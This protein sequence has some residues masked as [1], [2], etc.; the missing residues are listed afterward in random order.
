MPTY[1]EDLIVN[2]RI[3]S[4]DG[5][6]PSTDDWEIIR[7]G[8]N[9]EIREPE[10][11]KVWA[12][13]SD[14]VSLHL[15]GTPNLWVDG[16]IGVG[17]TNTAAKIEIASGWGD[18]LFLRQERNLEGGGGFHIHNPWGDSTI[19]QGAS[20]RNRLGISYRTADGRDLW[21]QFVIHGPTGNVGIGT[22]DPIQKLHVNGN[23][24]VTGDVLLGNADCA[25]EFT[26]M[27][28]DM[29][30]PGTVMVLNE[31]DTISPCI[32]AYD[33]KVVGVIS[34]AGS[35]K[36]AIILD[37]QEEIANRVPISIMGKVICKV[38]A[39]YFGIEKGDLLTTSPTIGH[40]MKAFD[41][42]KAF[43]TVIGKALAPLH[44]GRSMIPILATLQ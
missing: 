23:I 33:K 43:G 17:T 26:V 39:N 4:R 14:D 31:N 24:R 34:G 38:D 11:R 2:G 10:Q 37:K 27:N 13:F 32:K 7:D 18:W 19:P 28:K 5:F 36:P 22:A 21:G 15:I 42:I 25:E 40:A 29:V 44:R 12:R 35:Y 1:D 30:D 16:R 41:P 6:R 9:L 3:R 8:E 20:S